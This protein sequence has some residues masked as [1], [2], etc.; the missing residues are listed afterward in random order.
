[1]KSSI[2]ENSLPMMEVLRLETSDGFGI[3]HSKK[4]ALRED[5]LWFTVTKQ[6][7]DTSVHPDPTK[8][9]G[10]DL[11][12]WDEFIC[13]FKDVEQYQHWVFNPYWRRQFADKGVKMVTYRVPKCEVRM[14]K[15]QLVFNSRVAVKVKEESLTN[16]L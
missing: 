7:N 9:T 12:Y 16:Y 11:S 4:Y 10:V 13:G 8:D 5:S 1:M 2:V 3:Y 14:G 15:R 6:F